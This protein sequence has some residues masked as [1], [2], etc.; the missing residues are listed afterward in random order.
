MA[1]SSN[2]M[3]GEEREQYIHD[4]RSRAGRLGA[5]KGWQNKKKQ[6][7]PVLLVLLGVCCD[8]PSGS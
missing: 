5:L 7:L 6:A 1:L 2:K 3:T 8:L 4:V